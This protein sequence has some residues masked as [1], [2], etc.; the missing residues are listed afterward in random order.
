MFTHLKANL[1][2]RNKT[3]YILINMYVRVE[4]MLQYE[5]WQ[6]WCYKVNI[7]EITL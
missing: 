1:M 7:M 3:W 4:I 5:S 2:Q 6:K